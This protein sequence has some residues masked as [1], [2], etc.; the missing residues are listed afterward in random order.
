MNSEELK[1]AIKSYANYESEAAYYDHIDWQ[2][3]AAREESK[4]SD[5]LDRIFQAIDDN[6]SI[7]TKMSG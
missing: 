5:I 1:R 4:A 2:T 6:Y 7:K 3:D